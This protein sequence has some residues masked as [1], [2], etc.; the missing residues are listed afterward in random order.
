MAAVSRTILTINSGSSSLKAS[1]FRV[2]G[3][4]RDWHYERRPAQ[5]RQKH[6]TR[7]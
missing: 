4:R 5:I 2:D 3:T 6:S 1:L 7:C